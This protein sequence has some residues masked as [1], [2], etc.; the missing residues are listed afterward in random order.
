MKK[1]KVKLWNGGIIS[2]VT[3]RFQPYEN[4]QNREDKELVGT[5]NG[6]SARAAKMVPK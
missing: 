1:D 3:S 6:F 5:I 2:L 4:D